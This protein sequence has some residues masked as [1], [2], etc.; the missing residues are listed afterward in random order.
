MGEHMDQYWKDLNLAAQPGGLIQF[1]QQFGYIS[2]DWHVPP[3]DDDKFIKK[4][5]MC[6]NLTVQC[7]KR[8]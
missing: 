4:R 1:W 7:G 8:L 6:V 3:S 5:L 2:T